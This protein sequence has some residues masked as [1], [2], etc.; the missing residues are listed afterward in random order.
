MPWLTYPALDFLASKNFTSSTILEIG[1]GQSSVFWSSISKKVVT[2]E[3]DKNWIKTIKK[4][5]SNRDNLEIINAPEDYTKQVDFVI[6]KLKDLCLKY[7]VI[8]IDGMNRELMFEISLDY[9]KDDGII[10]CDDSESFSFFNSWQKFQDFMRIDFYGHQPGVIEPHATS[11][12]FK[13]NCQFMK[14]KSPLYNRSYG[15]GNMPSIL[16]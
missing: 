2:F 16:S 4:M 7:D 9:L 10:I 8:I 15:A 6:K 14:I 11:I 5:A 13:E 3:T 1:G 12:L